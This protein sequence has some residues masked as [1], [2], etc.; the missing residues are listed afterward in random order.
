MGSR[1]DLATRH[2]AAALLVLLIG[3]A[4][5]AGCSQPPPA[6]AN[7]FE[8]EV[9]LSPGSFVE[10][11]L[12]MNDS[13]EL[14]YRWSTAPEATIAFD[15][16]SHAGGEV[17][18]HERA[19]A[20]SGEGSF[21]APSEGTYSLLWENTADEEITVDVAIEGDFRIDSIVP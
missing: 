9:A 17:R 10:V 21:T 6:P 2:R 20:T 3:L 13:A 18:Y 19:N 4:A 1:L 7:S 15:V 12:A 14:A 11:N 8:R 16:H 5:L